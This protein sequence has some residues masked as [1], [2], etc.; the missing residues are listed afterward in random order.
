MDLAALV[1][2]ALRASI[3]LIVFSIGLGHT[4][5]D[6]LYLFRR[7]GQLVRSMLAM[8]VI[9][10]LVAAGLGAPFGLSPALQITLVALGVSPVPPI[11]P[12]KELTAGGRAPY[13]I[14]LLVTA[15]LVAIVTVPIS[16]WLIALLFRTEAHMPTG[17]VARLV[18]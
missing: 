18:A 1:G 15:A 9:M 13:A 5:E 8:N 11:L 17:I 2:L 14:S 7:P 4:H 3:C 10:P 12:K 6:A 16:L